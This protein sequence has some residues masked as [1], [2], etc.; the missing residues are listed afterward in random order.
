MQK[1]FSN[2]SHSK[3]RN[4][5]PKTTTK[6][7]RATEKPKPRSRT[8]SRQRPPQSNNPSL[9]IIPLGGM[10]EV[11]KNMTAFEYGGD[12]IIVD[13]GIGFPEDNMPGIDIV[14]PD[15]TYVFQHKSKVRGVFFT[16]GHEDHI[17]SIAWLCKQVQVPIYGSKMAIGLVKSKFEDRGGGSLRSVSLNPIKDGDVIQAGCFSVEFIHSTHSIADANMLAIRTPLGTVLHTGD[18]KIDYTPAN[19]EPIALSRIAS[20]GQEKPLLLLCEST[21]IEKPGFSMSESKVAESFAGIFEKTAGRIIVATFSSN[22]SR[23]QQIITAAEMFNRKVC[24]IGRSVLNVFQIAHSLGYMKMNPGTLIDINKIR[25]IPP[26]KLVIISTGSQGEPLSALTRMAFNEHQK[27]E[28]STGDTVII[29]ASPIPGNEKPIYRVINELYLRGANVIYTSLA[30]VH[31]SG[32]AYQEELK[33]IHQLV[34]AKYF[35]PIHGEYRMLFLHSKLAQ[36]MGVKEE[37]IFILSNGDILEITA[38]GAKITGYIPADGILIDGS[39]VGDIG[40]MVLR[41]RKLLSDDGVLSVAFAVSSRTGR[42]AGEPTLQA[43]GFLYESEVEAVMQECKDKINL[44]ITKSI[45]A[46]KPISAML[47]S[48]ALRDQLRDYLYER[49]KRRPII[50]LS[51]IEIPS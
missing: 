32:H 15:M 4:M 7:T 29:S 8:T 30:E 3:K 16:H 27:I 45:A 23:I 36:R 28:I 21:N 2:P 1:P 10:R 49:T 44:F 13:C 37:D 41:D 43:R 35:V 34:K 42:L 26:E 48:N 39:G 17:G 38:H 47:R 51:V 22:V 24:L 11:G 18:F 12:M 14:I 50:I 19:G 40:N 5:I 25:G 20:I 9:K 6:A 33:L 31:A 46:Q